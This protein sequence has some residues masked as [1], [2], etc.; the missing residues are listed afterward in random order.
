MRLPSN[1]KVVLPYGATVGRYSKANPHAGVDYYATPDPYWYAPEQVRVTLITTGAECGK[2][3]DFRSMDGTRTYRG[4]HSSELYVKNGQVV[5]GGFRMGRM[6]N[7]GNAKDTIT[8]L[9]FVMWVRGVRVDADATIKKIMG[10]QGE[11]MG[12][13]EELEKLAN[14]RQAL[15]NQIGAQFG[16][17]VVDG[18]T[19]R[20]VLANIATERKQMNDVGKLAEDRLNRIRELEK[21]PS[22][23]FEEISGP[24]YRRKDK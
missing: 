23:E 5:S 16:V 7:T 4:C 9:H 19:V 11:D 13:I 8:H 12:R 14:Q 22:P 24:I 15:L 3:I 18:N 6:G 10:S 21:N 2:Q 17:P 20:Q 1:N